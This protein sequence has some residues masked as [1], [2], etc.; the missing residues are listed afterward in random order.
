M[1]ETAGRHGG[2]I[3]LV[4]DKQC[5]KG[6]EIDHDDIQNYQRDDTRQQ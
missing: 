6:G 3:K 5:E 4:P 1:K 2:K